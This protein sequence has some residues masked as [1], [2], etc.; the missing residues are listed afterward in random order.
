MRMTTF[1]GRTVMEKTVTGC[2]K[3]QSDET[4]WNEKLATRNH[5]RP[6]SESLQWTEE[7]MLEFRKS[8]K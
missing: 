6:V 1:R 8:K 3:V 5:R 4:Q 2:G 7:T